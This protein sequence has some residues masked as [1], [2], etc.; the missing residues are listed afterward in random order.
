MSNQEN[1]QQPTVIGSV[2]VSLLDSGL[3][4]VDAPDGAPSIGYDATEDLL[5]RAY[6]RMVE[7]RLISSSV[8]A[9][10]QA[11]AAQSQ[12]QGSSLDAFNQV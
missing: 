5:R 2:V 4:S 6:Q 11:Q 12:S 8:S 9:L 7:N 1:I 3:I 10:L